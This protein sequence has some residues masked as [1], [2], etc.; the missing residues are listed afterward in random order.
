[1]ITG[2]ATLPTHF[3]IAHA[4]SI[5][6]VQAVATFTALFI[7]QSPFAKV[8]TEFIAL[9]IHNIETSSAM[10]ATF[11]AVLANLLTVPPAFA[12]QPA[13]ATI[14]APHITTLATSLITPTGSSV[15]LCS[16]P[17]FVQYIC[18]SI[19][20]QSLVPTNLPSQTNKS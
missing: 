2:F 5:G 13:F 8:F 1:V 18:H 16:R 12:S 9:F 10:P 7:N 15:N 3:A 11:H 6:L 19:S 14:P 4:V 20:L 17:S